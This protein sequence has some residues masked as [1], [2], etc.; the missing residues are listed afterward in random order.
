MQTW[1]CS[2]LQTL[3][4][5]SPLKVLLSSHCYDLVNMPSP[6]FYSTQTELTKLEFAVQT[7]EALNSSR[8]R[9]EL[10]LEQYSKPPTLVQAKHPFEQLLQ[11]PVVLSS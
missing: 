6:H 4:H 7:Q 2:I 8:L 9:V 10:Q 5:P 1:S 3:E 11:L